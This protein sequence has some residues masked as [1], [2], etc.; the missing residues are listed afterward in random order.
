MKAKYAILCLALG[1][2]LSVVGSLFKIMLWTGA[3]ILIISGMVL[4]I[5]GVILFVYKLMSQPK[6]K[7]F[8][9]K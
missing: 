2:F 1:L 4:T 8:L 3:D 5:T 7:D 6:I 9:N